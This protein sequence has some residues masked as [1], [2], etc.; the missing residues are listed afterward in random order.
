FALDLI[1]RAGERLF[2]RQIVKPGIRGAVKR[3]LVL[4]LLDRKNVTR[5]LGP[6]KQVLAVVGVKELSERVDAADHQEQI[7]LPPERKHG[8]DEIVTRALVA[9]LDLEAVGEEGEE[10]R[11]KLLAVDD[12]F[13]RALV[14]QAAQ[15]RDSHIQDR[16]T[17]RVLNDQPD[18]TKR[19]AAQRIGILATRRLLVDRP[20]T[21]Q[22]IDLVGQ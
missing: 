6:C 8:I 4:F 13:S 12:R 7:V 16:D 19:G 20:E 2:L 21:N 3:A 17:K 1:D 10:F 14:K 11:R 22:R 5:A 9:K 18:D 15:C